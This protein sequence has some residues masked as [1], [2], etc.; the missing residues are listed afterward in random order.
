MRVVGSETV[1]GLAT[2]IGSLVHYSAR[3]DA[4]TSARHQSF[5]ASHLLCSGL[6]LCVFPIYLALVGRPSLLGA[7]AFLWLLS[8]IAFAVFLSRTGRLSTAHFISGINFAGLVTYCAW[9]TGGLV[10]G[11]LPWLIVVPLG[12][13]L[14]TDRR[15]VAW[16]AGAAGLG[17]CVLAVLGGLGLVP[18][19]HALPLSPAAFVFVGAASA[20]A[21]AAGLVAIVQLVHA[22][23]E[24]AIRASEERCRL[25]AEATNDL[26]TR[27]DDKG[28]V[29]F[30]SA[31]AQQL[32]GEPERMILGDGFFER[33][34]VTDRPAYFTT[35]SRC[36]A[37]N[38]PLSVEFRVRRAG[39]GA[40]APYIWVEMQCRPTQPVGRGKRDHDGIVA[41]TRDISDL[42]AREAELRKARDAAEG[43]SQA[44]TEFL[45]TMS[46]ELRTP[47]NA[48]IGFSEVLNRELY[49]SLGETR[50]RDYARLIHES[51]EHLLDVVN[52]ILDMS[53]IEA[54]KFQ[55]VKEPF[56][57]AS[58]IKS[59][60]DLMRHTAEKSSLSLKVDVAPDMPQLAADNRA[61]KQMLLNLIANAIKF[62]KPG[63]WVRVSA[64]V[65]AGYVVLAVA[66]NGVGIADQDLPKLGRPFVQGSNSSDQNQ[67]GTGLGLSVVKGL[68][69]LHGGSLELTSKLGEGTTVTIALPLKAPVEQTE[70][71]LH[72]LKASAA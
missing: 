69:R 71:P 25:L 50:Y 29:V 13:A 15:V 28:R 58:L 44:K 59:T 30:A 70:A 47:L 8:P 41:I 37:N 68:A 43:A 35:L 18:V 6:A 36:R 7:I 24:G 64:H 61:C 9:A 49:G 10:S 46:H 40:A 56:D 60:C 32:L 39:S 63:G 55:I 65:E 57:V 66:D 16:S 2:Y 3:G 19:L 52:D 23:S 45:A 72:P 14:A 51:G 26:V 11:L 27:H 42:K 54:G 5:I 20:M 22:Q 21:Y 33:V 53:K 1:R 34:H 38:E 62:T 17:L 12:A 31:A 67:E 4:L 48:V